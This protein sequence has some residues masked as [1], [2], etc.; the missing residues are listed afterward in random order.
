M[1]KETRT[2]DQHVSQLDN[3]ASAYHKC[4]NPEMKQIWKQKWYE[5]CGVIASK[6]RQD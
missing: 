6:I 5:M 1:N 2:W 4:E 3:L